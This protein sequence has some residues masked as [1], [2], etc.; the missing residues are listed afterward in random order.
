MR[1]ISW[2]VN[3]LRAC[4]QKGFMKFFNETDCDVFCIQETKLQ[5]DQLDLCIPGYRIFLNSADKKGYSGTSVITRCDDVNVTYGMGIDE[6]DHEGRIIITEL[7]DFRLLNVYVPNTQRELARLSYRMEWEEKFLELCK[8]L[9]SDKPLII[10]GDM[11]VAHEE[12]D[13]RNPKAN[14][15]NAGFTDEERS[16]M[17]RLLD[18]GF[19]DTFRALY[20]DKVAYTWWSY[21]GNARAKDIGW[22]IDYFLVS[23]RFMDRVRDCVIL[24]HI[25]GSDHCPVMLEL[26]NG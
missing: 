25:M 18:A 5:P 3:G 16:C 17:T 1:L 10:C 19:T 12:I 4:L 20:P 24:P 8:R 7:P 6:H 26:T 23:D 11:N 2:N 21:M 14:R 9:D 13:L 22:R 15:R